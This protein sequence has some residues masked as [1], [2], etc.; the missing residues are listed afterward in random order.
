MSRL[1]PLSAKVVGGF[2]AAALYVFPQAY[3]ISAKPGAVNYLEGNAQLDGQAL[4]VSSLKAVFMNAGS[5]LE[6]SAGKVE[7]L[8]APGV[9][10]RVGENSRVRMLKPSLIDTQIAIEAGE[11]ML[12]VDQYVKDSHTTV[13]MR[14]GLAEI[15]KNGLYRF[16]ADGEASVA[17]LD[18]KADV[19]FGERHTSLGKGRE[20]LLTDALKTREFDKN[21]PDELYAW[22]NVRAQY[23]AALT[24]QAARSAYSS[25]YGGGGYGGGG[26]GGGLYN[27]GFYNGGFGSGFYGSGWYWSNGFNSWLWMPGGESFSPFGWGFYGPGFVSY[28]PVVVVPVMAGGGGLIPVLHPHPGS[29]NGSAGVTVPVNAKAPPAIGNYSASPAQYGLARMQTAHSIATSG[30]FRTSTGAHFASSG[31][32]HASSGGGSFSGGGGGHSS[33]G[34]SSSGGGSHSSG[35]SSGGHSK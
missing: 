30:G 7:V 28:A 11:S 22:S 4:T 17:V 9:F 3:T 35:G 5:V 34:F 32:A 21:Q 26:Y 16:R 6:T 31:S 10:L 15:E 19:S 23:N 27:G 8:L 12:E 25:G 20:V 29:G 14:G 2:F 1:L 24:Y 18:G 13:S 33:G